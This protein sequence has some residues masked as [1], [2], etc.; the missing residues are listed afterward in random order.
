MVSIPIWCR[1]APSTDQHIVVTEQA[2]GDPAHVDEVLGI[3]ADASEDPEDRL[4][5]E[6][7]LD[8]PALEQVGEVVEVADVVALELEPRPAAVAE[9]PKVRSISLNVLRKT[10]SRLSSRWAASQSYWKVV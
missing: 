8:Q 3:G 5:E 4:D 9:D 10:W 7:R 2:V 6:R 1:P